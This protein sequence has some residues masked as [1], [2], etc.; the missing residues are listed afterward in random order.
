MGGKVAVIESFQVFAV[1]P[2]LFLYK[3]PSSTLCL[4]FQ[5]LLFLIYNKAHMYD[6]GVQGAFF[7]S[8]MCSTELS[9]IVMPE[10]A[11]FSGSRRISRAGKWWGRTF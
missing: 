11:S 4:S 6:T 1:V 3:E 8:S 2:S 5:R 9:R 10:L 7:S